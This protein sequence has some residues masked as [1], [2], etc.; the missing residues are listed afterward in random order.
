MDQMGNPLLRT[1]QGEGW[2]ME[3]MR[4]ID[5]PQGALIKE[6]R[7]SFVRVQCCC[8][9]FKQ[10]QRTMLGGAIGMALGAIVG[11]LLGSA[12]LSDDGTNKDGNAAF[13]G[14]WCGLFPA[15][16]MGVLCGVYS[17]KSM[18]AFKGR[19]RNLAN[20]DETAREDDDAA[21][22]RQQ[23][24][25]PTGQYHLCSHQLKR[26]DDGGTKEGARNKSGDAV[27]IEERL[28]PMKDVPYLLLRRLLL[29]LLVADHLEGAARL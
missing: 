7:R 18:A 13:C 25:T 29:E 22:H 6:P 15:S 1:T 27:L 12:A 5:E 20:F 24:A 19:L 16:G 8:S 3:E 10:Q 11:W 4:D 9:I 23:A 28:D 21:N 14:Q 17:W 2:P 26:G